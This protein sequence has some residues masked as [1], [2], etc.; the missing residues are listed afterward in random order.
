[1]ATIV[2][3]M[4][5]VRALMHPWYPLR[6]N[7][8]MYCSKRP[9]ATSA[10]TCTP[11]AW[12]L[13]NDLKRSNS[14][15]H[16]PSP[17]LLATM[18]CTTAQDKAETRSS[19]HTWCWKVCMSNGCT[20]VPANCMNH[21]SPPVSN[22][23]AGTEVLR[24]AAMISSSALKSPPTLIS[25]SAVHANQFLINFQSDGSASKNAMIAMGGC[26]CDMEAENVPSLEPE[27]LQIVM[28]M[29]F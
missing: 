11:V 21:A 3:H 15:I 27:W 24:Q 18:N 12:R 26:E 22:L 5:I 6:S 4:N 1:M 28:V 19:C 8:E 10:V 23:A 7:P 9:A 16:G 2:D 13:N 29:R 20:Q 25:V 17:H 14:A